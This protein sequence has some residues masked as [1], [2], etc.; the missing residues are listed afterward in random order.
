MSDALF[1][2]KLHAEPI[3]EI[4]YE[5]EQPPRHYYG[6]TRRAVPPPKVNNPTP[7]RNH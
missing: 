6:E 5:H 1:A 2:R 4:V 3:E 7:P